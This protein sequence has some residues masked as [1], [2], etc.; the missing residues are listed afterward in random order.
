MSTN[1]NPVAN[2]LVSTSSVN[3]VQQNALMEGI[4]KIQSMNLSKGIET[5]LIKSLTESILGKKA[6]KDSGEMFEID[7]FDV[8]EDAKSNAGKSFPR[9]KIKKVV[10]AV[11]G[12]QLKAMI[13]NLHSLLEFA[14]DYRDTFGIDFSKIDFSKLAEVVD[15]L[16]T[17]PTIAKS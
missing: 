13:E 11:T 7:Y 2:S 9:V 17:L 10:K 16:Q 5:N 1:S 8:P 14:T 3:T 15:N 12:S 6:V 4:S